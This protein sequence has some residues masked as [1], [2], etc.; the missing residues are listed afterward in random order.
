MRAVA[1]GQARDAARLASRGGGGNTRT[2]LAPGR[3][4]TTEWGRAGPRQW[5]SRYEPLQCLV[6]W[7]TFLKSF[8]TQSMLDRNMALGL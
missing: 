3:A 7:P 5:S 1:A 4:S 8:Y 2:R 6:I